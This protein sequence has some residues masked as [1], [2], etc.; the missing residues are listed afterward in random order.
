MKP[1]EYRRSREALGW[2]HEK[3]AEVL[4]RTE[5]TSYRYAAGI[6]PVP[7]AVAMVIRRLVSDKLTMSKARFET[8]VE[9]L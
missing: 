2:T 5:R 1:I 4:G 3:L 6:V 7:N 8:M 9:R